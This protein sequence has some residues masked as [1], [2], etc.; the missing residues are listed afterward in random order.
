[1]ITIGQIASQSAWLFCG[2]LAGQ[3]FG[4]LLTVLLAARLGIAGL[5]EYAFVAA[6]VF[7]ANVMTTFGTDMVVIRELAS[8]NRTGSWPAALAL[9][10]VLSLATIGLLWVA[11]PLIPGQRPEVADALRVFSWSLVP[12]A[13]SSIASAGLRGAGRMD[14]L[15]VL[16]TLAAAFQLGAAWLLVPPG[17]ALV[18]AVAVLLA[19]Q[20]V[21]GAASWMVLAASAPSFRALP[22]FDRTGILRMARVS[23]PIGMLGVLGVLYQRL[24]VIVLGVVAGP[25]ATG[26]FAG[27]S[28]L[29]EAAKGGHVAFFGAVYPVMAAAGGDGVA[30]DEQERN[31]VAAA[32]QAVD[33]ARRL[34]LG[35]AVVVAAVLLV[36]GPAAVAV[37]YGP[38]FAPSAGAV[39][40]LAL[41]VV[42]SMIATF[43]SLEFVATRRERLTLRALLLSLAA[44]VGLI[45]VMVPAIGWIGA[46]WAV[47]AAETVQAVA[48]EVSRRGL[49]SK[50]PIRRGER[51]VGDP[52]A[53]GAR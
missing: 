53:G 42:P 50:H 20:V 15:A 51:L 32:E 10:L 2:R 25:V 33:R 40:I 12:A 26:W 21:A 22:T 29:A 19:A 44:L 34:S 14:R 47:L 43:Q 41:S 17:T 24:G 46:C 11:A 48:M 36:A 8:G 52:A 49:T 37:L 3:V 30:E 35:L 27:A 28:R 9:Q 13:L 18:A 6:V 31:R 45:A 1:M 38:A 5:G 23:A 16:G 39:A 7:V 4:V